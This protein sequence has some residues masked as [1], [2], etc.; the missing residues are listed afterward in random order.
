MEAQAH[1][2]SL[3]GG[4]SNSAVFLSGDYIAAQNLAARAG[5]RAIAAVVTARI[6]SEDVSLSEYV[7]SQWLGIVRET[8]RKAARAGMEVA[9]YGD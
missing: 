7:K 8:A 2:V 6:L 3:N 9:T 4:E 1:R 5:R